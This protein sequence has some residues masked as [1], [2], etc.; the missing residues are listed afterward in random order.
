[1]LYDSSDTVCLQSPGPYHLYFNHSVILFHT[2]YLI[3]LTFYYW[4]CAW[5][6]GWV[7]GWV[8]LAHSIPIC[9]LMGL[10]P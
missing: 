1:M 6:S 10:I 2:P 5:V 3:E 4:M 9:I 8:Q 7:G